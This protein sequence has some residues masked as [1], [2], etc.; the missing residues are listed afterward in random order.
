MQGWRPAYIFGCAAQPGGLLV[1]TAC[2]DGIV[3]LWMMRPNGNL[4]FV[5][6]KVRMHVCMPLC[7]QLHSM[8]WHDM[9]FVRLSVGRAEVCVSM[10]LPA[11]L[12]V[13]A[14][15]W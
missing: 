14:C 3:R 13:H 11:C 10:R 12:H 4:E 7:A 8:A 2:S 5:N 15:R 6:M 9:H 1:A